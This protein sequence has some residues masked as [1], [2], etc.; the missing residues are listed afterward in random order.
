MYK[1][2]EK[3]KKALVEA[4]SDVVDINED[5]AMDDILNEVLTYECQHFSEEYPHYDDDE[6][7]YTEHDFT[8]PDVGGE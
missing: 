7:Q 8:K 2:W 3:G 4:Y 1:L 5:M 6:P